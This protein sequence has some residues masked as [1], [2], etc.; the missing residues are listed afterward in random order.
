M[1]A[2]DFVVT[3]PFSFVAEKWGVRAVLWCNLIPRVGMSIW[4]VVVGMWYL[5][6][7]NGC[8]TNTMEGHYSHILPTKAIIAGPF[9]AVL[10]G[11]CVLQSTIFT[12]TSAL[13]NDYVDR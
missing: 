6:V 5:F 10:G 8:G 13:A 7:K 3:V 1:R 12:L 11:E 2:T 9:L 4:A